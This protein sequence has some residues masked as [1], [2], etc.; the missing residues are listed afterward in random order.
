MGGPKLQEGL[1]SDATRPSARRFGRA[2]GVSRAAHPAACMAFRCDASTAAALRAVCDDAAASAPDALP[3]LLAVCTSALLHLDEDYDS[4]VGA[5]K[6]LARLMPLLQPERLKA[7]EDAVVR[8]DLAAVGAALARC[9]DAWDATRDDAPRRKAL[10]RVVAQHKAVDA[11]AA[12]KR[13]G[14][15]IVGYVPPPPQQPQPQLVSRDLPAEVDADVELPDAPLGKAAG[16]N[17]AAAKK[18]RQKARQRAAAA[19]AAAAAAAIAASPVART[20]S[21]GGAVCARCGGACDASAAASGSARLCTV[22]ARP[23]PVARTKAAP[24]LLL[25]PVL[26]L[27]VALL[28]E[29]LRRRAA[30]ND[31]LK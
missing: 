2:H 8:D 20:P 30:A 11:F 22:C 6:S 29:V 21:A 3:A 19:E 24:P 31:T 12:G 27:G 15:C 14:C 26:A 25:L 1:T 9:R 13:E 10:L 5:Q 16:S 23:K 7:I 17:G 4:D 28:L 18:A